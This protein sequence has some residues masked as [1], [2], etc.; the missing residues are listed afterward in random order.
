MS[1]V[2]LLLYNVSTGEGYGSLTS[3]L[4]GRFAMPSYSDKDDSSSVDKSGSIDDKEG[5]CY[6]CSGRELVNL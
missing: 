1:N 4:G 3:L 2:G 5:H 6:G